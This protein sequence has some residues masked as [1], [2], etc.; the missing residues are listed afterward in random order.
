MQ[1][2]RKASI[3]NLTTPPSGPWISCFSRS[4]DSVAL[5]PRSAS[6]N[7]F[8]R[9][10]GLDA[11]RQHAVLEAVVVENI[12]ERGRDHAADAE[13]HQRPG[14]VLAR[15]AAAEIV[16]GDQD[17]GFAIG[18]LVE[19]EVGVLAAV[20]LVAHLGEQALAQP[21]ALDRLQVLLGDDHVGVDIDHLQGGGDAFQRGEFF[22]GL[23]PV[24][25][26]V[27]AALYLRACRRQVKPAGGN[28]RP[29]GRA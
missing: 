4:I 29:L 3:S 22:H 13:I 1:C 7:S 26:S 21:G 15:R 25:K 14:R 27:P 8:S 5:A 18:R 9:S 11:D 10:S 23:V 28:F 12:A 17:L 19:H 24:G 2:L 20:V 16:A 6:S